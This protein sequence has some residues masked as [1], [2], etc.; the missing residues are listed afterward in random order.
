MK[1]SLLH[2][3]VVSRLLHLNAIAYGVV[4]GLLAGLGV[5]IATIWLVTMGGEA[6]GPGEHPADGA[7]RLCHRLG[8]HG[9]VGPWHQLFCAPSEEFHVVQL[10]L[11]PSGALEV[12]PSQAGIHQSHPKLRS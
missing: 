2:G 9:A 7:L 5:F 12:V 10:K 4:A 6:I 11:P 3:L 8:D 1:Q